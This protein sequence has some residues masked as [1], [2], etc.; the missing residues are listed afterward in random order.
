MVMIN[1][2]NKYLMC[3]APLLSF[4][5]AVSAS[6]VLADLLTGIESEVSYSEPQDRTTKSDI[7]IKWEWRQQLPE[8][9]R[10]TVIPQLLLNYNSALEG[11]KNDRDKRP[12]NYADLNGP[13][14][15]DTNH[16]IELKEAYGDMWLGDT[17]IRIGKQQVVWGQADGLKVLDIVNPQNFREYNLPEFED[18]RVPTWMLNV[19]QA[20]GEELTLQWLVIPDLTFNELADSGS[21][22]SISSPE[23]VPQPL[24]NVPIQFLETDRPENEVEIGMRLT[25]F[26]NG[27]DVGATYF[28]FYQDNPVIYRDLVDSTIRV[29]PSYEKSQLFGVSASTAIDNWVWKIESGYTKDHYFL[30]NN[31][32]DSGIKESDEL[33]TVLAFDYHGYTDLM[34]SY[35]FFH[36]V[37]TAYEKSVIRDKHSLKHTLLFKKNMWNETLELRLFTLLNA[38]YDDGQ[39]RVKANYKVNDYWSVFSGVDYF[40]GTELGP[41]GQFKESS[42]INVGWKV[43]L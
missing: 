33:A 3:K 18:S 31:L 36:S 21:Q 17:S 23:L 11:S 43:S 32:E 39:V 34:V 6:P 16:R 12:S 2:L 22:F 4:L 14:Y 26:I 28:N 7:K 37:I 38:D 42:R 30:R 24:S 1:M 25:A 13:L 5:I 8:D 41:F 9:A 19:Q 35:Q 20:V 27:W 29:S 10:I 15:E 40:Y